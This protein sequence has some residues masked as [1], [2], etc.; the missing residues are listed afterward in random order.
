MQINVKNYRGLS[1]KNKLS[2]KLVLNSKFLNQIKK[3]WIVR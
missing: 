1:W 2:L 3:L